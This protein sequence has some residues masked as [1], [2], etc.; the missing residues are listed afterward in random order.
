MP[1][2]AVP[3][4]ADGDILYAAHLNL[5]SDNQAFL[6]GAVLQTNPGFFAWELTPGDGATQTAI[7]WVIRH[8]TNLVRF[9]MRL[10]QGSLDDIA[11]KF[12]AGVVFSE[13]LGS[14][15]APY[16]YSATVDIAA[17]ALVVGTWYAVS[18]VATGLAGSAVNKV[19]AYDIREI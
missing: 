5:L 15:S 11:I 8:K 3:A 7:K 16:T 12:G 18:V 17:L 10:T 13:T 19:T 4:R 2:T 9:D 1:Y 6:Y 14:R